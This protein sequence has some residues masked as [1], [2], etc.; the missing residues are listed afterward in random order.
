MI[1]G[2][3]LTHVTNREL[4]SMSHKCNPKHGKIEVITV[5][6]DDLSRSVLFNDLRQEA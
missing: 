1:V 3:I 5:K 2:I 4:E 6:G